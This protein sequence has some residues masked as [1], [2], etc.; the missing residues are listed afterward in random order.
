M[1]KP[2]QPADKTQLVTTWHR[3]GFADVCRKVSQRSAPA[4]WK[5]SAAW[6]AEQRDLPGLSPCNKTLH[7]PA[8]S[9]AQLWHSARLWTSPLASPP[10]PSGTFGLVK[11]WP[12]ASLTSGRPWHMGGWLGS[13]AGPGQPWE[14][15]CR[16][17]RRHGGAER[18]HLLLTTGAAE[19]CHC[20]LPRVSAAISQQGEESCCDYFCSQGARFSPKSL[21]YNFFVQIPLLLLFFFLSQWIQGSLKQCLWDRAPFV[22][23]HKKHSRCIHAPPTTWPNAVVKLFLLR[24]RALSSSSPARNAVG[25]IVVTLLMMQMPG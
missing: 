4:A 21:K 14:K 9:S 12:G 2:R 15:A 5:V 24:V 22:P 1:P 10:R 13:G 3:H 7:V 11:P 6:Q 18:V 19:L 25:L 16:G 20:S 17:G 8:A 23:I